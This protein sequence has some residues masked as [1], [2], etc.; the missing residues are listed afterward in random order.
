MKQCEKNIQR[1]ATKRN[2]WMLSKCDFLMRRFI[3]NLLARRIIAQQE[4]AKE[5][6]FL[7]MQNKI[8]FNTL[9]SRVLL[10]ENPI[11]KTLSLKLC[12]S[13]MSKL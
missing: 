4:L 13:K 12:L 7:I 1:N 3:Q 8:T 10:I 11:L 9:N 6:K 2:A 5:K